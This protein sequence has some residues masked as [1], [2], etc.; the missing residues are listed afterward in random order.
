M[1]VLHIVGHL[2]VLLLYI[3]GQTKLLLL[4]HVHGILW[5][6]WVLVMLLRA[7]LHLQLQLSRVLIML[8]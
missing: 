2:A 4:C 8:L 3:G 5:L 6:L 7:L 1:R